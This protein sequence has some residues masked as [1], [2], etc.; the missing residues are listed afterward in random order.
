MLSIGE[1]LKQLR[2]NQGL[3]Q[4]DLYG[5]LISPSFASR[6]ERGLHRVTADTLFAILDRLMIE[7]T[8][9][10]FIQRGNRPSTA[11]QIAAQLATA[12]SQQ[13]F[14]WL[15]HLDQRYQDSD[16][17]DLQALATFADL[18]ISVVDGRLVDTPRTDRIWRRFNQAQ[19]WT[20]TEIR[21]A[22]MWLL[23]ADAK[24]AQAQILQGI[25]K[26]HHSCARYLSQQTDIF[27]VQQ[28]LLDF[29]NL[30]FQTLVQN[31][32]YEDAQY[33]WSNWRPVD[34]ER[35]NVEARITQLITDC[36]WEWYFGDF[37][38][39][40]HQAQILR[41]LPT[42]KDSLYIHDVLHAYRHFAKCYRK[43]SEKA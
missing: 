35:L 13:N 39:A 30:A 14:P 20:L 11:Q 27:H 5:G 42:N 6:L 43:S 9:F 33:F 28:S 37:N 8:E 3:T 25:D 2:K 17:P 12:N 29:D 1:T 21:Q 31:H 40:D 16:H 36:F 4:N 19:L 10:Q 15:R 23:I 26:M 34:P 24:N 7:P 32:R 22:N 18:S 41:Q 38:Q